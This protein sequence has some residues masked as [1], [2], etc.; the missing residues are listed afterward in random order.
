M[1]DVFEIY[2]AFALSLCYGEATKCC[3]QLLGMEMGR[4]NKVLLSVIRNGNGVELA[5]VFATENDE[6]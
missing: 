4:G 2:Y 3:S 5:F 1:G 6:S